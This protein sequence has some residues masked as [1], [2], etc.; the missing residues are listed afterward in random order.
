MDSDETYNDNIDDDNKD[1]IPL[2][3]NVTQ[4]LLRMYSTLLELEFGRIIIPNHALI[5]FSKVP[6]DS[7]LI[8]ASMLCWKI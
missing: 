7:A 8:I 3:L 4:T 6:D 1:K 2:V 5:F